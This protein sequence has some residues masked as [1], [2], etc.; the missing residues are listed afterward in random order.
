V[1]VPEAA[2]ASLTNGAAA[3]TA[4]ANLC[5]SETIPA[6]GAA[7]EASSGGDEAAATLAI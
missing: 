2:C 4:G 5:G 6:S 3:W 1:G 7:A